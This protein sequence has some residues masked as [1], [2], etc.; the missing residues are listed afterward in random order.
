MS[1]AWSDMMNHDQGEGI[2][3]EGNS[4]ADREHHQEWAKLLFLMNFDADSLIQIWELSLLPLKI[5]NTK[6][7]ISFEAG[8]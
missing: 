7:H 3:G 5:L 8:V 2:R 4:R 1:F 6:V